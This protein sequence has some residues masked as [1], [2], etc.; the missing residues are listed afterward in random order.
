MYL[1]RDAIGLLGLIRDVVHGHTDDKNKVM[2]RV[3]RNL[4]LYMC[5]QRAKQANSDYVKHFRTQV[6]TVMA[7]EGQPWSHLALAR[8]I[9]ADVHK[10]LFNEKGE[11]KLQDPELEWV[12][13]EAT[14]RANEQYLACLFIALANG[15]RY[16]ELKQELHNAY[17]FK[18]DKYPKAIA[19]ALC[20]LKN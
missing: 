1:A 17:L 19:E 2:A 11:T 12:R 14:S 16:F 18:Q 15:G 3:E 6:K 7:H 5:A 13:D 10:E 9:K 8:L 4:A 20:L